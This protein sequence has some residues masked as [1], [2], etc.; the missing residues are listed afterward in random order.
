MNLAHV[1][2]GRHGKVPRLDN[3]A[4]DVLA[5]VLPHSF[6]VEDAEK[7]ADEFGVDRD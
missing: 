6:L 7:L 3:G 5:P 4:V 1:F 2:L